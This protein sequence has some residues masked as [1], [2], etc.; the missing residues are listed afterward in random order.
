VTS[1]NRVDCTLVF[2]LELGFDRFER[3]IPDVPGT[4]S[5]SVLPKCRQPMSSI[6]VTRARISV[7]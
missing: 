7:T 1:M 6:V 4:I 3:S 2:G 5:S